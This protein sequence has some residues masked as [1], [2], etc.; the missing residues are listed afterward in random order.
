MD[1]RLHKSGGFAGGAFCR[2]ILLSLFCAS[3]IGARDTA[4]AT[5]SPVDGVDSTVVAGVRDLFVKARL[6]SAEKTTL[7]KK[8][9]PLSYPQDL[10][11]K[12]FSFRQ[13]RK[14]CF[15]AGGTTMD[16]DLHKGFVSSYHDGNAMMKRPS[17]FRGYLNSSDS[18]GTEYRKISEAQ[19]RQ[20][21]ES[22][23]STLVGREVVDI[24]SLK[25]RKHDMDGYYFK[26]ETLPHKTAF[27]HD[28]RSA[29]VIV[30]PV[31]GKVVTY[32]GSLFPWHQPDFKP[33]VSLEQARAILHQFIT[34]SALTITG[35]LGGELSSVDVNQRK[36]WVWEFFVGEPNQRMNRSVW[37]DAET[38]ELLRT[39]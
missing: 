14:L 26:Y 37:I 2:A 13:L 10:A 15:S 8:S 31:T 18:I 35:I 7:E 29:L 4:S 24:L 12:V 17:A 21:A 9:K 28:G 1:W 32:E 30:S 27:F 36:R 20:V 22:F 6:I 5:V 25:E 19:A 11:T 38:G 16:Y 23:L 39:L 33:T 34:D 3:W